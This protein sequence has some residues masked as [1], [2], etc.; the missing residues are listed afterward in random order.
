[1]TPTTYDRFLRALRLI[2]ARY[3]TAKEDGVADPEMKEALAAMHEVRSEIRPL[4]PVIG[5][6]SHPGGARGL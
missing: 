5:V 4:V 6:A 3:H 1:M 2:E